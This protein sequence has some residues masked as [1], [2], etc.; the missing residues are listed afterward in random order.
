[1]SDPDSWKGKR[2]KSLLTSKETHA[3]VSAQACFLPI[4]KEGIAEFNPVIFNYQYLGKIIV[5]F[6]FVLDLL[7]E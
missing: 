6:Y 7:K 4:P 5:L 2:K 1:M 3:L